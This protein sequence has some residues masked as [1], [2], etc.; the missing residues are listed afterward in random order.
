MD[1]RYSLWLMPPT[2][3]RDRFAALIERLSERLGTPRFEPHLTL[4]SGEFASSA[5]ALTRVA[6]LAARRPPVRVQLTR[7]DYTDAY[8]RCLFVRAE[9]TPELLAL[10]QAAAEALGQKPDADFMPHL[11]VVYGH[12]DRERKETI[13]AEIGHRFDVDFVADRLAFYAPVGEPAAWRPVGEF[14]LS[15][16]P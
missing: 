3:V 2:P 12:L 9:L 5:D 4:S 13:L 7:A 15:G 8:F 6:G 10:Q 16:S 11:S 14:G 1:S